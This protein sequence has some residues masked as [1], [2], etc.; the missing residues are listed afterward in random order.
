M[1]RVW[2][3]SDWHLGHKNIHNFRCKERGFHLQFA[4]EEEH[5]EW[6]IDWVSLQR[7]ETGY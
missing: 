1:S 6:L 2:I 3:S 5:R 4:N 7:E